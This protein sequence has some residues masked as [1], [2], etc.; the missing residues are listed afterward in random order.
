[1]YENYWRQVFFGSDRVLVGRVGNTFVGLD[2]AK[3]KLLQLSILWRAGISDQ[4]FF[5]DVELGLHQE[6][7]RQMILEGRAGRAWEY[8]CLLCAITH[9]NKV[10]DGAIIHPRRIRVEGHT[11]YQMVAGGLIWCFFVSNHAPAPTIMEWVLKENGTIKMPRDEF[12]NLS[13]IQRIAWNL[14]TAGKLPSR[15]SG[16]S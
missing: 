5:R 9:E 2:Y 13:F 15:Q 14:G 6:K 4:R 8:A 16:S 3:L 12:D 11:C 7:L 10:V 1:M